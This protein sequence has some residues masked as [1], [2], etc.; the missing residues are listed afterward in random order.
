MTGLGEGVPGKVEPAVAG[1][2]L[3]GE[4]VATYC[5]RG[6]ERCVHAFALVIYST[7]PSYPQV[8]TLL[9]PLLPF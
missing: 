7:V 1:Q 9:C 3:V 4:V 6:L 2:E 5:T 8:Q